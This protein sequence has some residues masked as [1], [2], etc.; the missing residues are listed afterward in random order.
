MIEV[1]KTFDLLPNINQQAYA[2]AA[3]KMIRQ[4]LQTPGVIEFRAQRNL[5]GCPHV[6][7]TIIWETLADWASFAESRERQALDAELDAFATNI[8]VELWGPSPVAP[9]P[10]RPRK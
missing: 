2:E 1:N 6:R 10:I 9:E 7:I 3:Q 4:I 8:D 5:L